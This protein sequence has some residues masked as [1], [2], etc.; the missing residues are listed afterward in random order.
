MRI[1]IRGSIPSFS[2]PPLVFILASLR[3]RQ[4]TVRRAAPK[5]RSIPRRLGRA[6]VS[7][8]EHRLPFL[9]AGVLERE[10]ATGSSVAAF[11]LLTAASIAAVLRPLLTAAL[12]ASQYRRRG[13]RYPRMRPPFGA[14]VFDSSLHFRPCPTKKFLNRYINPGA[15]NT[16]SS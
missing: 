7:L 10:D 4:A 12:P 11:L 1:R 5:I 3:L 6:R 9:R 15:E 2:P 8:Q 16:P 13:L 14:L